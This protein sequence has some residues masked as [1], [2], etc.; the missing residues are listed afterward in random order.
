[1][2]GAARP[3]RPSAVEEGASVADDHRMFIDGAW[4]GSMEGETFEA[5]SPS[6]GEVIGTI[7]QGTRADVQRAIDA[8]NAAFGRW[9]GL[10]A[11]DRAAAMRR[12]VEEIDRRRESLART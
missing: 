5:T 1:M 9:S 8:A 11:F 7:P 10:S 3:G 2:G 4:V 6:T 12:V